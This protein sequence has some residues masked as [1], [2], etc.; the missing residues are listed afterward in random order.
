MIS[1]KKYFLLLVLLPPFTQSTSAA[2]HRARQ[3]PTALIEQV[4]GAFPGGYSRGFPNGWFA[5]IRRDTN[6]DLLPTRIRFHKRFPLDPPSDPQIVS[7]YKSTHPDA[8]YLLRH[9]SL[10][11]GRVKTLPISDAQ[12]II[13]HVD[14]RTPT[15]L[16]FLGS[17]YKFNIVYR[18]PNHP[19]NT[20][21]DNRKVFIE[22][23]GRTTL[24]KDWNDDIGAGDDFEVIRWAGDLDH[25]GRLDLIIEFASYGS[26]QT[27]L[28]LSSVAGPTEVLR[29]VG[30]YISG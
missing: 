24:L 11:A 29:R 14:R 20:A 21:A 27:C 10:T 6:T 30:C 18:G 2:D 1:F 15:P 12:E 22:H 13:T 28:F 9:K 25:D 8:D 19:A 4:D 23:H 26:H 5:L 17:E 16:R 7:L 3:P